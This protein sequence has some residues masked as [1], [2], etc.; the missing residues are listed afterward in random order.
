[1]KAIVTSKGQV[2]IPFII[3]Q[4]ARISTGSK[5]D[6]QIEEDGAIKVSIVNQ[7][8]TQLKGIVKSKKNKPVPLSEMKKA[9]RKSSKR[10]MK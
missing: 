1:M 2:T 8:I 5:L 3:R 6:F 7:E 10:A 9:I 4:K